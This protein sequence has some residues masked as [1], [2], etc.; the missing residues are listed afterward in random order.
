MT[1]RGN[2]ANQ[3]CRHWLPYMIIAG[4]SDNLSGFPCVVGTLWEISDQHAVDVAGSFYAAL[5]DR[6][7]VLEVSQAARAL[8]HAVRELRDQYPEVPS[9]WASY[10]HVGAL[11]AA[12]SLPSVPAGVIAARRVQPGRGAEIGKFVGATDPIRLGRPG[13]GNPRRRHRAL[14]V[15]RFRGSGKEGVKQLSA[16]LAI[17]RRRSRVRKAVRRVRAGVS[18]GGFRGGGEEAVRPLRASPAEVCLR[19]RCLAEVCLR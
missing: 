13:G 16:G 15:A 14:R 10:L 1:Y 18:S 5:R 4:L 6:E 8:H 17:G 9:L 3:A 2:F 11:S 12:G 7:G 19:R